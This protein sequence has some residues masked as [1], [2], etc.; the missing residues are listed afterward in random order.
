MSS[1]LYADGIGEVT[2]TGSIV[3]IDFMSLSPSERD[4]KNN[5][6]PIFRQRVIMPIEAF[7]NSMDLL[8][9]A[10]NGLVE[11]GALRRVADLPKPA[12]AEAAHPHQNGANISPN[13]N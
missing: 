11:A 9:K 4:E 5:P 8:Q 10:L 6:K 12:A 7:G 2:I 13:F 1:E 3:R